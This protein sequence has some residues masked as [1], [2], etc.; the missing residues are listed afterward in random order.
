[1]EESNLDNSTPMT[2]STQE[3]I[4]NLSTPL[5]KDLKPIDQ[6]H[7]LHNRIKNAAALSTEVGIHERGAL[8]DVVVA[9]RQ[10]ESQ[11]RVEDPNAAEEFDRQIE[12]E[13]EKEAKLASEESLDT[14]LETS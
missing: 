9:I 7:E 13:K 5:D 14:Q 12:I 6:L 1:M 3:K 11:I 10:K 2:L 4:V 8:D